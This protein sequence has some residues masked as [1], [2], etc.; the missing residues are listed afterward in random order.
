MSKSSPALP[1]FINHRGH[2][3]TAKTESEIRMGAQQ[4]AT[5]A[6]FVANCC[7][8]CGGKVRENLSIR[9]WVQCAQFGAPSFRADPT[10][11]KCEWQG[12]MG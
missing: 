2:V 7:P 9:G 8:T 12:N 5:R 10:A 11:P 3:K 6:A 4:D 1:T